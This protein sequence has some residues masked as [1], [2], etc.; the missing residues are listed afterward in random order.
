[1]AA[2]AVDIR[3]CMLN[4]ENGGKLPKA[5]HCSLNVLPVWPPVR[6]L[7]LPWT[8]QGHSV[9]WHSLFLWQHGAVAA[10]SLPGATKGTHV[11]PTAMHMPCIS[12]AVVAGSHVVPQSVNNVMLCGVYE[13]DAKLLTT[14]VLSTW[15]V[16][17]MQYSTELFKRKA[18]CSLSIPGSSVCRPAACAVKAYFQV[19]QRCM[20]C[21]MCIDQ[22]VFVC[23]PCSKPATD[24]R[25]TGSADICDIRPPSTNFWAFPGL[26]TSA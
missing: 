24:T 18:G 21:K 19:A 8:P 1:M 2:Q 22:D 17:Y 20:C 13:G 7:E 6:F 11:C 9:L 16:S 10:T 14:G 4:S 5:A 25:A 12:L 15:N 26:S 3:K 23:L